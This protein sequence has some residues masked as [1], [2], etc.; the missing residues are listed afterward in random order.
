MAIGDNLPGIFG[1]LVQSVMKSGGDPMYMVDLFEGRDA[2]REQGLRLETMMGGPPPF[3]D[4]PAF[5]QHFQM[6][7]DPMIAADMALQDTL[8]MESIEPDTTGLTAGIGA[9][10]LFNF[11]PGTVDESLFDSYSENLGVTRDQLASA[12]NDINQDM[13]LQDATMYG[14]G[15]VNFDPLPMMGTGDIP[16]GDIMAPSGQE[17]LSAGLSDIP[18]G[19]PN[20][21]K[22]GNT[23]GNIPLGLPNFGKID[24]AVKN[25]SPTLTGIPNP[26][27]PTDQDTK[28]PTIVESARSEIEDIRNQ[29]DQGTL[30]TDERNQKL[31]DFVVSGMDVN[32]KARF[33]QGDMSIVGQVN[34]TVNQYVQSFGDPQGLGESDSDFEAR[35]VSG[36]GAPVSM[37]IQSARFQNPDLNPTGMMTSQIPEQI[38]VRPT[39]GQ[40]MG[41]PEYQGT[42]SPAEM[43]EAYGATNVPNYFGG[44][45]AALGRQY[46]PLLGAH[47][48]QQSGF[49]FGAPQAGR[50]YGA[51][52]ED[53]RPETYTPLDW[54]KL[55]PSW[56]KLIG[57]VTAQASS[58]GTDPDAAEQI[59]TGN[60]IMAEALTETG[61]AGKR[62]AIALAL[63]RYHA[64]KP[65]QSSY[66]NRAVASSLEDIYDRTAADTIRYGGANTTI[67]FLD[68][69]IK[70]NPERF[71]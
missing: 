40:P 6:T 39:G 67:K 27:T 49:G 33:D 45:D 44:M 28:P 3:E 31:E 57:Y 50:T 19:L 8:S 1:N 34:S 68:N 59:A 70:L 30:T 52:L 23:L 63:A 15:E 32:S 16:S 62:N 13:L 37:D 26:T 25:K 20:W 7:G 10:A 54:N 48:L 60:P 35:M 56:E 51:F 24:S 64:G 12:Y 53:V 47:L 36:E 4:I 38:T 66:A 2:D 69:L 46:R 9:Q 58:G 11:S 42:E 5:E 43:F 61:S 65:V 41:L 55:A 71:G 21:E 17:V 18:W 29:W 22:L 14:T